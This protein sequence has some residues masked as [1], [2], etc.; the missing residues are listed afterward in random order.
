M[1]GLNWVQP[2]PRTL[3][4]YQRYAMIMGI[5]LPHFNQMAGEKA[6]KAG[7]CG[8]DIWDQDAR[9]AL[10]ETMTVAEEMIATELKYWPA[11]KFIEDEQIKFAEPGIRWDWMDAQV[12]TNWKYVDCFGTEQLTLIKAD[13][14][15]I[16]QDLDKDPFSRKETAQIGISLYEDL[17]AC[18]NPCDVAVFIRVA[19]GAEDAADP[20]WEVR[21][22]KVDIDGDTMSILTESSFLVKPEKWA[23]TQVN[24]SGLTT[25]ESEA[26]IN[27]FDISNLVTHVDVYCRT[28]NQQ[29]PVTVYWDGICSC[30][31]ACQHRTQTACAQL[32]DSKRGHFSIRTSEWNGSTNVYAAPLYSDPPKY[33]KVNYRA[34]YPID[35]RSCWMNTRLE[36]AIVHLTNVL[37]PEPPCGYCDA[38]QDLWKEDRTN[39]DPLTPEAASMPWDLYTQGALK[40]WRIVK[41]MAMGRGG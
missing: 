9:Q 39:I 2:L 36:R 20:R 37:L 24:C 10:V 18:S 19:D 12:S 34:G 1:S 21:P 25:D 32:S 5:I 11:L 40:A 6:P 33:I 8:N 4:P 27:S 41:R 29:S 26:W 38:A 31:G 3:M 28:I 13:A 16:Y 23:L 17:A 15:V 35:S 22:I 30:S 7:G 14:S